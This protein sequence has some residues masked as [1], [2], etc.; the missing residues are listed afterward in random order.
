M[1]A[2]NNAVIY[3]PVWISK[4]ERFRPTGAYAFLE[5]RLKE[6]QSQLK[7]LKAQQREIMIIIKEKQQKKATN[8]DETDGDDGD[9]TTSNEGTDNEEE[10]NKTNSTIQDKGLLSMARK[11]LREFKKVRQN[12]IESIIDM[13]F[14]LD[15]REENQ[16]NERFD[17]IIQTENGRD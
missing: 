13:R 6:L 8:V 11:E 3:G 4:G 1:K 15:D 7:R 17:S 14:F 12:Q 2:A 16:R 10:K 9:F 5:L